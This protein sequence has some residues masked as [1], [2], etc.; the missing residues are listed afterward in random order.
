MSTRLFVG[1]LPYTAS[2]EEVRTALA[3]PDI[4]IRSVRLAVDRETNR[5]RGFGFVEVGSPEEADRAIQEWT[6]RLIG[7]RP[8]AIDKAHDRRPGGAGGPPR[9]PMGS[10]MPPRSGG[11]PRYSTPPPPPRDQLSEPVRVDRAN[12]IAPIDRDEG[13]G[14]RRGPAKGPSKSAQAKKKAGTGREAP[15]ERGGKWRWDPSEDY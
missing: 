8:I 7:G 9:R 6:G 13:E 14:R 12:F 11:M 10:S 15:K 5:G 2:E 1:N 4:T 3:S